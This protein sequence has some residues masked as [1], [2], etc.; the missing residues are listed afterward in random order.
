MTALAGWCRS[1][2][3][4]TTGSNVPPLALPPPRSPDLGIWPW[5][6][7]LSMLE[8]GGKGSNEIETHNIA[9]CT[10]E[11]GG[12]THTPKICKGNPTRFMSCRQCN[13]QLEEL[14][15]LRDV[16]F[17]VV[18]AQGLLCVLFGLEMSK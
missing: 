10:C 12:G 14:F 3:S 2:A 6:F 11:K 15:A 7:M 16:W 17:F 13:P 8:V 1:L 18:G 4:V 9:F 5:P